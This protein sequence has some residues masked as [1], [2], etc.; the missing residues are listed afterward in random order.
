ML[1]DI[2]GIRIC[3]RNSLR[4][5]TGQEATLHCNL[6]ENWPSKRGQLPI[7]NRGQL[8]LVTCLTRSV[9]L[10]ST[11]RVLPLLLT[12]A[13]VRARG[14]SISRHSCLII[15]K[16]GIRTPTRFVSGFRHLF[17]DGLRLNI[18][19]TGPGNSSESSSSLTDT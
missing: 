17:S 16:L 8:K 14:L 7:Q 18:R 6:Y 5:I 11:A 1:Y 2:V 10:T 4:E 15:L 12:L 19:V 3:S 9:Y 13:D